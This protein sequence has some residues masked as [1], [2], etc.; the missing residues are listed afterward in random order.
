[1]AVKNWSTTASSNAS[2]DDINWAEGQNPS[3][4]NNSARELMKDVRTHFED[5]GYIQLHTTAYASSTTF[6]IA[7]V[8]VRTTYTVGRRVRAV[9]SSTGTI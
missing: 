1:M 8:D 6:T 5:G 2:V 3:T 4:V 7:S 9:G